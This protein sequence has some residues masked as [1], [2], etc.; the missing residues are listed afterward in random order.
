MIIPILFF[1]LVAF[2]VW[3]AYDIGYN[4]GKDDGYKEGLRRGKR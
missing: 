1:A 3:L 4:L 2:L